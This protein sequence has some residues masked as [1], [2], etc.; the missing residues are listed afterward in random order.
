MCFQLGR[1]DEGP[2]AVPASEAVG[3]SVEIPCVVTVGDSFVES[4][5]CLTF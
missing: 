5:T 1:A 3:G 2:I 4:D